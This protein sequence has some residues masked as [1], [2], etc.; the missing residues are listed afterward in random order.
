MKRLFVMFLG[1]A[2]ALTFSVAAMADDAD[3]KVKERSFKTRS[4]K[5][6]TKEKAT[7]KTPYDKLEAKT[8]AIKKG[9][10]T[11][12]KGKVIRT[13][14]KGEVKKEKVKFT[15]YNENDPSRDIDNTIIVEKGKIETVRHLGKNMKQNHFQKHKMKPVT[16]YSTYNPLKMG[17]EVEHVEEAQP[18]RR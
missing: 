3:L 16:I 8:I 15:L 12:E 1:L 4:G 2:V 14:R 6:I 10:F 5:E 9:K 17:W 11:T 18:L 7:L 13:S